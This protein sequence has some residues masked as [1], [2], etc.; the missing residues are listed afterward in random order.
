MISSR[1]RHFDQILLNPLFIFA[2]V[3]GVTISGVLIWISESNTVSQ[4]QK[5][6]EFNQIA[7]LIDSQKQ[8]DEKQLLEQTEDWIDVSGP[9][10]NLGFISDTIWVKLLLPKNK[11]LSESIWNASNI[12]LFEIANHQISNISA[13]LAKE[14]SG[15]WKVI[16]EW[17]VSDSTPL[18]NRPIPYNNF[19]FPIPAS[20][21][22]EQMILLKINNQFSMK[23]LFYF[24]EPEQ[25][26]ETQSNRLILLSFYFGAIIIIALYNF[27]IYF[28]VRDAAYLMYVAFVINFSIIM[29]IEKGIFTLYFWPNHPE[30][31]FQA[32]LFIITMGAALAYLFNIRFLSLPDHAPKLARAFY[33]AVYCWAAI[34]VVTLITPRLWVLFMIICLI[35]PTAVSFFAAGI[36]MFRKGIPAATYYLLA[37][38]ILIVSVIYHCS[39][40]LGFVPLES[41]SLNL[42]P[43]GNLIEATLLSLGLA[44]RIKVLNEDKQSMIAKSE[45]KNDFLATMS[46]EIRTPMNG[47]LGMAQLLKETPL[48]R[49]QKNY[50]N[51][52][53]GSGRTLLTILNDI[54]DYSKIEA[55]KLELENISF[56]IRRLIDETASIFALKALEKNIF[57]NCHIAPDVPIKITGDPARIQ[58]ILTNFLSNAFKFT[59]HGSVIIYVNCDAKHSEMKITVQDTGIGI[60]QEKVKHVF[61]RFTQVDS[62]ISRR[63]GGTGLGLAISQRL[64]EMMGGQVG[65]ESE[66]GK[67][68]TFWITLPIVEEIPFGAI[69]DPTLA[70]K[71]ANLS[72]LMITPNKL[73][74][75]ESRA[76]HHQAQFR[77]AAKNSLHQAVLELNES[78]PFDF[79][80]VDQY[81]EDFSPQFIC[82]E[83]TNQPWAK[84]SQVIL[85]LKP[86]YDRSQF[87]GMEKEPWVEEYPLSITRIQ[88]HFL[89]KHVFDLIPPKETKPN[90]S[91]EEINVL[92]VEDNLVNIKVAKAY[93]DKLGIKS[94]FVEDGQSALNQV[95]NQKQRFD[96]IFMDCEMP[97][98]DG[99][100]ATKRIREWEKANNIPAHYICALSAHAM[101][102]HRSKCLAAG[103]NDFLSKPLVFSE[104]ESKLIEFVNRQAII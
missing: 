63:Y 58:Q 55:N 97:I 99:Y 79:I 73:F 91:L 4:S 98:L 57:Y 22:E 66:E 14:T 46:H 7:Y 100:T 21:P 59:S 68:S 51:T 2:I 37:W 65:V 43:I 61:S 69:S 15:G 34:T 71:I 10:L 62:S 77:L 76:Y 1:P 52:I 44:H 96:V 8:L 93:L 20:S 32:Y 85:T 31:D 89:G 40:L 104:I 41:F 80:F 49:Q 75:E 9:S 24:W 26:K 42:L 27:M 92:L 5:E 23:L 48:N 35:I 56:N 54:L 102:I 88:L 94:Q 30:Y 81:C 36:L 64:I 74:I 3:V 90:K 70:N 86:G 17:H 6:H 45:A 18:S 84:N 29:A 16:D 53:L 12:H 47:I 95:C 72:F 87:K 82:D 39:V 78:E 38:C 28:Y 19:V 33:I 101:D 60:P 25:F 13:Y 103:M 83:L 67:G 50:L 11:T